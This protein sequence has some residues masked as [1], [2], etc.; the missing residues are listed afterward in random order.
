MLELDV[1]TIGLSTSVVM[2]ML[3]LAFGLLRRLPVASASRA[4]RFWCWGIGIFA[5]GILITSQRQGI[6]LVIPVV[7]GNTLIVTGFGIIPMGVRALAGRTVHAWPVV[8]AT[9]ITVAGLVLGLFVL[10]DMR[11]RV[12]VVASVGIVLTLWLL[13]E[14]RPWQR[15]D[16][17]LSSRMASA[18]AVLL[19]VALAA[20]GLNAGLLAAPGPVIMGADRSLAL[21]LVLVALLTFSLSVCFTAMLAEK[22]GARMGGE[23]ERRDRLISVLAHDLRT[24]FN[25]L[26][27]GTEALNLYLSR[28]MNDRAQDT[29]TN[30]QIAAKQAYG[31]VENLLFWVRLQ[32]TGGT[33]EAV[34]VD[35]ACLGAYG[36]LEEAYRQKSVTLEL[37][38]A[39]GLS[40]TAD[41]GGLETVLRN[42][43]SNA[44]KYSEPGS[45]V[46]VAVHPS[47][48]HVD[49]AVSDSG[50]GMT[51]EIVRTLLAGEIQDSRTGTA[52][53]PG[54]GLGIALCREIL[55]GHGGALAIDSAPGRGSTVTVRLRRAD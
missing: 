49:I 42:L 19:I 32:L 34:P 55:E 21:V 35:R 47:G 50:I 29:A 7:V 31:L 40:V 5:A 15:G 11:Y 54:T 22:L 41:S 37:G 17:G 12:M 14:L 3:A 8:A 28:G 24:P 52:G 48:D 10:P 27:G 13:A 18:F 20:R 4:A 9:C 25:T 46:R 30:I 45:T 26:I 38:E 1:R 6:P 23:I 44:L 51:P 43:Y 53:E 2:G 36:P 33:S 39:T 16:T